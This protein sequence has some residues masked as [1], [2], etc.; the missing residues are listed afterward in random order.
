MGLPSQ[1]WPH[2]QAGADGDLF[3]WTRASS[4]RMTKLSPRWEGPYRGVGAD[5][6][7]VVITWTQ[8]T[9][10][11]PK[12]W[13]HTQAGADG[14]LFVWTRLGGGSVESAV[15]R[16]FVHGGGGVLRGRVR[17]SSEKGPVL[18]AT[19]GLTPTGGMG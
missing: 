10:R 16:V 8:R 19:S 5:E 3:V 11:S 7:N 1:F 4:E 9:K 17:T 2:T 18:K 15:L 14:D 6:Y 13:P 12:F